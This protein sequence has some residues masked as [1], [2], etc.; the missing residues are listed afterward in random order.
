[1]NCHSLL[2]PSNEL[3]EAFGIIQLEALAF[4]KSIINFDLKTGVPWVGK[5]KKTAL[6]LPLGDKKAL[7]SV[8]MN[9]RGEHQYLEELRKNSASHLLN[10]FSDD[11]STEVLLDLYRHAVT[12]C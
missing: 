10:N 2:F 5:H 6:T 3:S 9:E 12:R 4:G 1:M 7:R 8:L 11:R